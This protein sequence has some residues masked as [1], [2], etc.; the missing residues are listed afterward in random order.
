MPALVQY[1]KTLPKLAKAQNLEPQKL[2]LS[3]TFN[4]TV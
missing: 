4:N 3:L 1:V 2:V